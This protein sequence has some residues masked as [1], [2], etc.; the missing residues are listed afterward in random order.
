MASGWDGTLLG[1][2][3]VAILP[4]VPHNLAVLVNLSGTPGCAILT[5]SLSARSVGGSL[6]GEWEDAGLSSYTEALFWG[7]PLSKAG[8]GAPE[9]AISNGELDITVTVLSGV[10]WVLEVLK[11]A[12]SFQ[13]TP[14]STVTTMLSSP[15]L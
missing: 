14:L 2:G 12:P 10:A 1:T 7:V 4:C 8:L 3:E 15:L 11:E 6:I 9:L 13:A 5:A